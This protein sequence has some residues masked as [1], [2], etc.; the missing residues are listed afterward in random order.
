MKKVYKT[1]FPCE[2][3]SRTLAAGSSGRGGSFTMSYYPRPGDAIR[4]TISDMAAKL[5]PKWFTERVPSDVRRDLLFQHAIV[6]W[7]AGSPLGFVTFTS[8][9]SAIQITLMGTDPT[10][11]RRGV[12]TQMMHAVRDLARGLGYESIRLFTKPPA[13]NPAYVATVEFY[14][15]VGFLEV[16]A[17][18]ELWED[19]AIEFEWR[20]GA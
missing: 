7:E 6:Y 16:K 2:Q 3:E 1:A 17:Y 20:F 10:L 19:G 9:D 11:H 12:G 4:D 5:T 15:K 14:K 8:I 18:T 13:T